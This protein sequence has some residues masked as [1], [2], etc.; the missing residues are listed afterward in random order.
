MDSTTLLEIE[1][2]A[3]LG[4]SRVLARARPIHNSTETSENVEN[5]ELGDE[6]KTRR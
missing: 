2:L 5:W 6:L 3:Y 1:A 4:P